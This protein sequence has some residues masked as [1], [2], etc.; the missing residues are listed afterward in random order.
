[1]D[2][3]YKYRLVRDILKYPIKKPLRY[4][5]WKK[6]FAGKTDADVNKII[7]IDP[8]EIKYATA[9][10]IYMRKFGRNIDEFS[11]PGYL[12]YADKGDVL[13]GDWDKITTPFDRIAE[14]KAIDHVFKKGGQWKDTKMYYS[15]MNRIKNGKDAYGATSEKELESR[16]EYIERL[17]Q[18]M[19]AEG[20]KQNRYRKGVEDPTTSDVS[21]DLDEV[22]INIGRDGEIFYY[23]K[24]RHRL[25]IAKVLNI[26]NI[27]AIVKIRH[28]KWQHHRSDIKMDNCKHS[29]PRGHPDLKELQ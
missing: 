8:N 20:Y 27:P 28:E 15:S 10:G 24:G 2:T 11:R 4:Y 26:D 29:S 13:K 3:K 6:R 25:S 9:T 19:K 7:W 17:Y 23:N 21:E 14:Y 18:D 16:F 12:I 22:T 1:M 5:G